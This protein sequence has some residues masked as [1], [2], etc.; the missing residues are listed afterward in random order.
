[1]RD[2]VSDR[3]G[4]LRRAQMS[5]ERF[6]HLLDQY[7]MLSKADQKLYEKYL[8]ARDD[9]SLMASNDAT[10]RRE[11]KIK[12]YKQENDL[13]LKLEVRRA[14]VCHSHSPLIRNSILGGC[15]TRFK[16]MTKHY[17]SST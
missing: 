11:T 8:E 9:F 4:V 7:S 16:A 14:A 13:K 5:Y 6:L 10:L 1:M 15:H 17:G 12:R 2:S 3:K